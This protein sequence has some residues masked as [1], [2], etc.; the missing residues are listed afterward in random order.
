MKILDIHDLIIK[1]ICTVVHYRGTSNK[2]FTKSRNFH[3]FAYCMEGYNNMQFKKGALNF[4]KNQT[5][6]VPKNS[7]HLNIPKGNYEVIAVHFRTKQSGS[8]EPLAFPEDKERA[9]LPLFK[10]INRYYFKKEAGYYQRSLQLLYAI[11]ATLME[12]NSFS[13]G[14]S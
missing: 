14:N 1:E 10:E 11:I 3:V 9:L 7:P 6:F 12:Q 8:F 4:G 13:T 5:I 2:W